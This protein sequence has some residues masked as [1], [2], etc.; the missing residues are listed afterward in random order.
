[1]KSANFILIFSLLFLS[2]CVSVKGKSSFQKLGGELGTQVS[3]SSTKNLN[4]KFI[5]DTLCQTLTLK[6]SNSDS[7]VHFNLVSKNLKQN[8][9]NS[10]SGIAVNNYPNQNPEIDEDKNG[11]AYPSSEYVHSEKD[12]YLAIR[13]SNNRKDM[14]QIKTGDCEKMDNHKCPFNTIGILEKQR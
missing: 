1:M 5:N 6:F 3:D 14:V 9:S 2:Q 4:Y 8:I 11:I 10:I 7:L 12:C 13:V